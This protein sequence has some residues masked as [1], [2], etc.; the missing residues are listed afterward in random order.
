MSSSVLQI[1]LVNFTLLW[2]QVSYKFHWSFSLFYESK[3][4]CKKLEIIIIAII[5]LFIQIPYFT[6]VYMIL[7]TALVW[8]NKNFLF[9]VAP[10]TSYLYGM[11][12]SYLHYNIQNIQNRVGISYL[13]TLLFY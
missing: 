6:A 2:V 1:P 7:K 13:F 11:Y 12:Y 8:L 5:I 3:Y 4:H 10:K 9:S